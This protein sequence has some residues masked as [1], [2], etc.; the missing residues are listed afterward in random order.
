[1]GCGDGFLYL[2]DL[3]QRAVRSLGG[4]WT[5]EAKKA[6]AQA[7]I[8]GDPV[9]DGSRLLFGSDDGRLYCVDLRTAQVL[10][11][12]AVADAVRSTPCVD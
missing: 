9:I 12:V 3:T 7:A 4:E 5:P 6:E 10:G 8:H 11:G 1:M 2:I